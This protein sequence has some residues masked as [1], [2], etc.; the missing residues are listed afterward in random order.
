MFLT[1]I[2][3]IVADITG[4]NFVISG[5]QEIEEHIQ[6]IQVLQ[7]RNTNIFF[8]ANHAID[9]FLL[10]EYQFKTIYFHIEKEK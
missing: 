10:N 3:Q 4:N 7:E 9:L 8:L 2:M 6:H 1:I 5:M